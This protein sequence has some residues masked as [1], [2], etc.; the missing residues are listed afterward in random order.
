[1]LQSPTLKIITAKYGSRCRETRRRIL[2]GET[3]L[4]NPSTKNTWCQESNKYKGFLY[5]RDKNNQAK[6]V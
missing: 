2:A 4:L 5:I 3:I 6:K 1:M